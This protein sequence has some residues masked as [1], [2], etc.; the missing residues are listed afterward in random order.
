MTG[1]TLQVGHC[2]DDAGEFNRAAFFYLSAPVWFSPRAIPEWA[3]AKSA[4]SLASYSILQPLNP[5]LRR[6]IKRDSPSPTAP[7]ASIRSMPPDLACGFLAELETYVDNLLSGG[8]V[9]LNL[10]NILEMKSIKARSAS[11]WA[12]FW[13]HTS[14]HE[15]ISARRSSQR[16]GAKQKLSN[17]QILPSRCH[18]ARHA[19]QCLYWWWIAN[20]HSRTQRRGLPELR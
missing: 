11:Q 6:S 9:R 8:K 5:V 15:T 19:P 3:I 12:P 7:A 4:A 2:R 16:F 18:K 20:R 17:P 1:L 13:S 10:L 14:P